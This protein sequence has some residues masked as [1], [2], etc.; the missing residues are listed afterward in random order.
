MFTVK[1]VF[2]NIKENTGIKTFLLRGLSN[3]KG[4]FNLM[5]IG[6]NLKKISNYINKNNIPIVIA[7]QKVQ[8]KQQ[9]KGVGASI[10]TIMDYFARIYLA[11]K[12]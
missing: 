7:M 9:N 3:V 2:G 8:K 1:P 6:H 10:N 4:E 11:L 5:S 12:Y